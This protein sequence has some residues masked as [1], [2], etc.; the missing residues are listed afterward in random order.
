AVGGGAGAVVVVVS[1]SSW[2]SSNRAERL[3]SGPKL[4]TTRVAP[5]SAEGAAA[6]SLTAGA[7]RRANTGMASMPRHRAKGTSSRRLRPTRLV[8][9]PPFLA[10]VGQHG[11]SGFEHPPTSSERRG[12]YERSPGVC[13]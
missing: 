1:T 2:A 8:R 12:P 9:T 4:R 10:T 3:T 6:G 13:N 5:L 11:A 7:E